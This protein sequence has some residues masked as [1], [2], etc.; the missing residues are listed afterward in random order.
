MSSKAA[1]FSSGAI[2]REDANT[3]MTLTLG[4]DW[5]WA[6]SQWHFFVLLE[7]QDFM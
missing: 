5:P 7:G 2:W 6:P 1:H 4:L 3:P